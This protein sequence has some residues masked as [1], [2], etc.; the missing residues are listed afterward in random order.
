MQLELFEQRENLWVQRERQL[1]VEYARLL[2]YVHALEEKLEE[3]K[4][5]YNHL[6]SLHKDAKVVPCKP[7]SE[8]LTLLS[9]DLQN[10]Q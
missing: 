1:Q 5:K 2:N 3:R 9:Q 7:L 4:A 10:F 8:D 6:K